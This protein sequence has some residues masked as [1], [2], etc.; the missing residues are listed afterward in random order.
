MS[1]EELKKEV[2]RLKEQNERLRAE[3]AEMDE[4]IIHLKAELYDY[5]SM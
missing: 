4:I 5:M 2:E 1:E 3:N